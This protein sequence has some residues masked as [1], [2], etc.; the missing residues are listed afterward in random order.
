[1][2][3]STKK[4]PKI[5]SGIGDNKTKIRIIFDFLKSERFRKIRGVFYILFS[6]FLF[7]VM[8]SYLLHWKQDETAVFNNFEGDDVV[9]SN[10]GGTVGAKLGNF[11]VRNMFG[12]TSFG[13]T[14]LFVVYLLLSDQQIQKISW[15]RSDWLFIWWPC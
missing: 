9:A 4:K 13:F 2:S 3:K 6:L 7:V 12:I 14:L 15:S 5:S 1:M 10:V 8:I 11:F